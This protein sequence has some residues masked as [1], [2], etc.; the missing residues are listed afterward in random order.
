MKVAKLSGD[1]GIRTLD[2][3]ADISELADRVTQQAR[4][5]EAI[6]GAATQLSHDG[7]SVANAGQDA[8]AKAVAARSI[9]DDSGR[10][11]SAANHVFVDL[12]DQVSR[13]HERLDGFGEAL[14]TVAHVTNVISGIAR[15][16]NLLALNATIEAAR[17]GDAGRGFA[18]VAA[19]VKK[20]AQET[21]AATH[22]IEQ[23]IA[24]LT[25]EA[26]GMLDSIN[27]GA[28]TARTAQSDTRNIEALV[29]RL[30]SLMVDLSSN[31]EGVAERIAS[32]VGSAGEIRTGLAALA[33]TSA[34][35][36]GGLQRL[37]GRVSTASD[38]TNMLLQ[39]L[40]ESGVA[41]PDSPYISFSLESAEI[42]SR[43]MEQAIDS[44]RISEAALF[45][46]LP[47]PIPGTNPQQYSHPVQDVM[48]PAARAQ[49]EKARAFT[50]L[51]GM[52]FTDR[53][54]FGAIAMPER[55]HPQ[56]PGEDVWN[57]EY[58]RQGLIFDFADTREQCRTM[59]PFCIKAY[60]RLTAAG[61]VILL[62]QV[63]ASI[64]VKGRH[65]GILQMAYQD[66]G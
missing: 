40:A 50:G 33:S 37:S 19:E 16:T 64:H 14:K 60:R 11:L 28:Q 38:D 52:T 62:K 24:A 23:S 30:G 29:E 44:G 65:W 51:F 13:I 9:I 10:Q 3:Q 54:A 27:R 35:N 12:I 43:A 49:Q 7:E 48:L 56:R 57:A 31:T 36:A 53:N 5:I 41:I 26:G 18:V 58:S 61:D 45:G 8:R 20:L 15:Q 55:A 17:A 2:L 59:Q 63:I 39:Y 4:T 1:L 6:S 32:I 66:Q 34:D 47:T 46:D 21:G 22:T 25:S 42:V